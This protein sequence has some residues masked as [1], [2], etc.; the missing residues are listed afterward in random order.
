MNPHK[1]RSYP[2]FYEYPIISK[3]SKLLPAQ[4]Y[5]AALDVA[6]RASGA[7]PRDLA[8]DGC[9]AWLLR[10][11]AASYG[12]RFS[13]AGLASVRWAVQPGRLT[14]TADCLE[15]L[16]RELG[17]LHRSQAHML[18]EAR[19]VAPHSAEYTAPY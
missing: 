6:K 9:W 4:V 17:P 5:D 16:I 14:P 19:P 8:T 2:D 15:L 13:Y 12:V 10:E 7:G 18:P 11:L 1:V 3:I